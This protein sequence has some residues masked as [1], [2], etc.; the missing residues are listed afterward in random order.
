M[1][2]TIYNKNS[3]YIT[4]MAYTSFAYLVFFVYNISFQKFDL[5]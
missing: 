4:G 1:I 5:I 3:Q 2:Q